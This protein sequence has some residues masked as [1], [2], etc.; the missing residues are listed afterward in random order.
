MDHK[1]F[2]DM[3]HS[4]TGKVIIEKLAI[5]F[6]ILDQFIIIGSNLSHIYYLHRVELIFLDK[7]M[8]NHEVPFIDQ[9]K[10]IEK[11]GRMKYKLHQ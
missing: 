11:F 9:W 10:T 5:Y 1:R 4:L 7:E 8:T 6:E 3:I 2:E